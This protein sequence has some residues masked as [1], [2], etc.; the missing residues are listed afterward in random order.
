MAKR[1]SNTKGKTKS[2]RDIADDVREK[3]GNPTF[4]KIV[5]IVVNTKVEE[6]MALLVK[7]EVPKFVSFI[8]GK[9]FQRR[10]E[11]CIP[12][13][14]WD[15]FKN[16]LLNDAKDKVISTGKAIKNL[17]EY[18]LPQNMND[19]T[20]QQNTKSTPVEESIFWATLY[21][22]L[23]EGKLL[24]DKVYIMHVQKDSG[25]IVAFRMH[26]D[27]DEWDLNAYE[28]VTDDWWYR[29]GVFLFPA[30]KAVA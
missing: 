13:Y 3:L 22:F 8:V 2:R 21:V 30:T 14:H 10:T 20:I 24:K 26:W 17:S 16:H 29:G 12:Q 1:T 11:G 19:T 27:D 18:V 5:K 9:V 4:R 25:E 23:S 15:G 6:L 28:F 7:I